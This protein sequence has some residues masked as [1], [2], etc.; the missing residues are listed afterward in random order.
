MICVLLLGVRGMSTE[1]LYALFEL[2]NNMIPSPFFV[3]TF[4]LQFSRNKPETIKQNWIIFLRLTFIQVPLTNKQPLIYIYFFLVLK[5]F[6]KYNGAVLWHWK[7]LK[8][9]AR[10]IIIERLI[11]LRINTIYCMVLMRKLRT[12]RSL[13]IA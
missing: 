6:R 13:K 2:R 1:S 9:K 3:V 10:A 5:I 12:Y 11:I 4:H 7:G 8:L